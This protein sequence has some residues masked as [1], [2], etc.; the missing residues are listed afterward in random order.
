MSEE[1]LSEETLSEESSASARSDKPLVA[2]RDLKKHFPIMQ[3]VFRRQ[4][5]AV[6]AVD[7]VN[8]EI[9]RGETLGLVGESG[10]GKST[11]GRAVCCS[12]SRSQTAAFSSTIK[13]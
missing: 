12:S 11:T 9:Y 1:T 6:K 7:G 10:S 13:S 8:F 3:G 5:G 2:V 4:V